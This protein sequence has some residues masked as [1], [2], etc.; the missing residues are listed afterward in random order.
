MD[1]HRVKM[2]EVERVEDLH[3]HLD[4]DDVSWWPV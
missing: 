1:M 3:L 4:L 2:R